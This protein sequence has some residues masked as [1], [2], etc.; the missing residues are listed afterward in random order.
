MTQRR[1][2]GQ[3]AVV[4]GASSGIGRRIALDLD[5]RGAKVFGIARRS[6]EGVESI[7]CD[8]SD[9][10]A[11][12]RVLTDIGPVDVLVQAA[13]LEQRT[14]VEDADLDL[15]RRTIELNFF[16]AVTGTLTVVPGMLQRGSGIVVNISSDHGRAPAPGT[17]AYSAS[18]AALSA[19][20]ESVAHEVKPRGVHLHVL[21]PGWVPTTLGQGA[22]DQGMPQPPRAVRRTEEQVSKLTLERMGGPAVDINAARVAVLAPV[23]RALAPRLYARTMRKQG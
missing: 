12:R 18:K 19:F 1:F 10:E 9:T 21:Y 15:Y 16:A 13:A 23:M 2:D 3:V 5:A 7:E 6:S 20:T 22:V 4:T 17:P 11:Y 8:V 14:R